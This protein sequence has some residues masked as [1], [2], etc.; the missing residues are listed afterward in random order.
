MSNGMLREGILLN[1][2]DTGEGSELPQQLLEVHRNRIRGNG[3]RLK[4]G[5]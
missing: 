5:K 2:S 4:E 1:S 3:T